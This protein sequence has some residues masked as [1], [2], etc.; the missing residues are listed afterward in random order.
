M[1]SP[2][3]ASGTPSSSAVSGTAGGPSTVTDGEFDSRR[4]S[5]VQ[6]A[7]PCLQASLPPLML[8]VTASRDEGATVTSHSALLP[9]TRDALRT[10]PFVALIA[11][12]R[13]VR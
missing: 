13:S 7:S 4:P 9:F 6:T 8:T 12:S 3:C 5:S 10:A 2:S 11:S 1:L